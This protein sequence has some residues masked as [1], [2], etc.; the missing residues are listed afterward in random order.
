MKCGRFVTAWEP[1][2]DIWG[3]DQAGIFCLF[4]NTVGP[5]VMQGVLYIFFMKWSIRVF[6]A[7]LC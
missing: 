7:V 6:L 1:W 4:G 3:S 5:E 2:R